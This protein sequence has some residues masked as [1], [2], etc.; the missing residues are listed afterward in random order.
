MVAGFLAGWLESGDYTHA[1]KTG[2]AA[3]SA[4][5]FSLGLATGEQIRALL[6]TV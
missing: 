6:Q 3:G 4:T 5:A 1:L 2:I